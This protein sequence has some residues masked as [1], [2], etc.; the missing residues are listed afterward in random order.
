[1]CAVFENLMAEIGK[2]EREID[3][4][5]TEAPVP[6]VLPVEPPAPAPRQPNPVPEKAPA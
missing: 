4:Q 1:M 6:R 2:P 3:V 5:P